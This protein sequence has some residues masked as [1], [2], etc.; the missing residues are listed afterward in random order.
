MPI[1]VSVDDK[2]LKRR[3]SRINRDI[4]KN[5]Q[6]TTKQVA[7][8]V[9]TKAAL[10]APKDSGEL[11]RFIKVIPV[12]RKD[13]SEYL[14]GYEDGGMGRGNPHPDRKYKGGEFSL[15]LWMHTSPNAANHPWHTGVPRFLP[16]ATREVSKEFRDRIRKVV[17]NALSYKTK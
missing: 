14:V 8:L 15:P 1:K 9:Q 2:N 11:R 3:I 5:G 4:T 17:H 6:A 10:Y 16:K 13:S 7:Q 12:N